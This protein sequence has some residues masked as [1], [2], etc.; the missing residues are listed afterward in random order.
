MPIDSKT[1]QCFI[2]S[3]LQIQICTEIVKLKVT[4]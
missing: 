4:I 3:H 1:S 2:H